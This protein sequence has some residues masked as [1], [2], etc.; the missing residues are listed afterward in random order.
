MPLATTPCNRACGDP[1]PPPSP[2]ALRF[3]HALLCQLTSGSVSRENETMR[4]RKWRGGAGGRRGPQSP[5]AGGGPLPPGLKSS[6]GVGRGRPWVCGP[7]SPRAPGGAWVGREGMEPCVCGGRRVRPL[8]TIIT[9]SCSDSFTRADQLFPQWD[10]VGGHAEL[11][12]GSA[13]SRAFPR[14]ATSK[15]TASP[16]MAPPCS[17]LPVPEQHREGLPCRACG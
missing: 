12:A 3:C 15:V 16:G 1:S 6:P 10:G 9:P 11:G 4:N 2:P 17:H 8:P 5:V 7:H 14:P 13:G